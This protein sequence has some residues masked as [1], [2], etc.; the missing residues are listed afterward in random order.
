MPADVTVEAVRRGNMGVAGLDW[1]TM[2]LLVTAQIGCLAGGSRKAVSWGEKGEFPLACEELTE[3]GSD[4]DCA[5]LRTSNWSPEATRNDTGGTSGLVT[6]GERW[7]GEGLR[8][9]TVL[10]RSRRW[11]CSARSSSSVWGPWRCTPRDR[12]IIECGT[13]SSVRHAS[14]T[15]FEERVAL[16]SLG[17]EG[18]G[19][20]LGLRSSL[21]GLRC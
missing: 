20:M 18:L 19:S 12:V 7:Y 3:L 6:W 11:S 10:T 2:V 21:A 5:G 16:R 8:V 1:P 15:R 9:K 14:G 4:V 13:V 17:A